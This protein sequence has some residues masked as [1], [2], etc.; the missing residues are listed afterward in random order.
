MMDQDNTACATC[1]R[2]RYFL[3][4]GAA[5]IMAIYLQPDWAVTFAAAMPDPLWIGVGLCVAGV[6]GFVVRLALFMRAPRN[7]SETSTD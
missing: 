6:A 5:M 1:L 4:V 7:L 3:A 2:I